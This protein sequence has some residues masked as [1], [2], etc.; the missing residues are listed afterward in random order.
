MNKF[1]LKIAAIFFLCTG[2]AHAMDHWQFDW[3]I[4]RAQLDIDRAQQ[5]IDRA[6]EQKKEIE[7]AQQLPAAINA[8]LDA[9]I[10]DDQGTCIGIGVG[11]KYN[12]NPVKIDPIAD[13]IGAFLS[14][15][16]ANYNPAQDITP[17]NIE[18]TAA[19]L[20][21]DLNEARRQEGYYWRGLVGADENDDNFDP[22]RVERLKKQLGRV[23]DIQKK[24]ELEREIEA[25]WAQPNEPEAEIKAMRDSIHE[26]NNQ[27]D[28]LNTQIKKNETLTLQEEAKIREQMKRNNRRDRI[29]LPQAQARWENQDRNNAILVESEHRAQNLKHILD[30][31]LQV[32]L[33]PLKQQRHE[34][35]QERTRNH[36]EIEHLKQEIKRKIEAKSEQITRLEA[37]LEEIEK[38]QQDDAQQ[39]KPASKNAQ[40]DTQLAQANQAIELATDE[41]NRNIQIR[42]ARPQEQAEWGRQQAEQD[43]LQAEWDRRLNKNCN[44]SAIVTFLLCFFDSN[45]HFAK[46]PYL[47][48][49]F[50]ERLGS[51]EFLTQP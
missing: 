49:T 41:R 7:Y 20:E 34:L 50:K 23:K 45:K 11:L 10:L 35:Y 4:N 44:I 14:A 16:Y 5:N 26:L 15:D 25:A 21:G 13:I 22:K 38:R 2:S 24:A 43:R 6:L 46:L 1:F 18:Q 3:Q 31:N 27:C 30:L 48:A 40:L 17:G 39:N 32:G 8:A 9:R 33:A 12:N 47:S 29:D 36:E 51:V 28:D 42:D 19:A 37:E